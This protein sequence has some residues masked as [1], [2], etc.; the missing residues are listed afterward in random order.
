MSVAIL[1]LSSNIQGFFAMKRN[2]RYGFTLIE[3]LVVIAIIAVLIGLLLPAVQK[4]REAAARAKCQ[5]NL[6]QL[7]L[8][9]HSFH[10]ANGRLPAAYQS[11][12][13]LPD[14]NFYRWSSFAL[15]SP[16]LEQTAIYN[17]LDLNQSLYTLTPGPGPSLRPIH[18]PWV[19]LPVPVFLCPS[20]TRTSVVP[21][22]GPANY[23]VNAGSGANGGAFANADGV[24]F[25]DARVKLTDII[26]GTSNTALA[27]ESLL[28]RGG[29]ATTAPT[30]QLEIQEVYRFLAAVVPLSE[31][32]C[33]GA[34]L[35]Q[36]DRQARWA[37]G[38]N[39]THQYVHYYPPNAAV[40]DC[41]S[42]LGNWKAARSRH[43][44]GVN[45]LLSDGSVRFTRDNI[46]I[47]TWRALST[48][49]GNEV[50]GEF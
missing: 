12:P 48:R 38:A 33:Q 3:L 1:I 16:Y 36:T 27:S 29:A 41:S 35:G 23:N 47:V 26:D 31:D 43:P 46:D 21:D 32:G 45:M 7:G 4:V 25:Q 17:N 6:K 37:D 19:V 24:I 30:T 49:A 13:D 42:R 5:N 40:P 34:T 14:G 28:G 15:I 9:F 8:A 22:W 18:A 44:G 50:L 39:T 2:T 10:D 20:D 11:R